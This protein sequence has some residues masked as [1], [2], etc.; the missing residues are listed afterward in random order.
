MVEAW[1]CQ[2]LTCIHDDKSI[3]KLKELFVGRPKSIPEGMQK[4]AV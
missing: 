4:G 2:I 1:S 3:W